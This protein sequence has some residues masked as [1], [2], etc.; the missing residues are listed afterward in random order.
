MGTYHYIDRIPT[1]DE[2][3][4]LFE[5]VGWTLYTPEETALAL[6]HTLRG[7]VAFDGDTLIGMG[8]VIGDGGKF[9][10]I[11]DFAVRPDYQ[12]GGVGA[13]MMARLLDWIKGHAPG[14]P[15]VGLFA[16]GAAIP[17]YRK[18]GLDQHPDALTGMFTVIPRPQP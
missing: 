6:Q 3:R 8:R 17:F 10:Y 2:H 13:A 1:A 9:Y 14:E 16:T 18:F 7:V 15:F 12:G 11:Q 5:A 4:A